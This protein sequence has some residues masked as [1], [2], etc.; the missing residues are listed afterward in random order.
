[1]FGRLGCVSV[2][3]GATTA[4]LS[5]EQA[6]SASVD[7]IASAMNGAVIRISKEDLRGIMQAQ[8][9]TKRRSR[10]TFGELLTARQY[11]VGHKLRQSVFFRQ[12]ERSI[13]PAL[14]FG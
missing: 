10:A 1:M 8:K 9:K 6:E 2:V 4:V 5:P 3:T 7:A 13:T 14:R 11:M 12:N